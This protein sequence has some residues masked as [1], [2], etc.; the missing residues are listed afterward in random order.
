MQ[1]SQNELILN[2]L[3][4]G[5]SITPITALKKFNCFRVGARIKNL[6]DAGH[7]IVTD[8]IEDPKTNKR[9]ASYRLA[10][11]EPKIEKALPGKGIADYS[12]AI[13][14]VSKSIQTEQLF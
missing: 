9:Y 1:T 3:R 10:G 6:R 12:R 2:H 7:D 11:V 8:M 5:N 13:K 14:Q 4:D